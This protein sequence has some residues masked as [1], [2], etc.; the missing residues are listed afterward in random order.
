MTAPV[1]SLRGL[2]RRFHGPDRPAV[3][4][5]IDLSIQAGEFVALLGRSGSGKTTLLRTLAGLD[6]VAEGHATLPD[7]RAVVFQEPRLLPWKSVQDN[8]ALGLPGNAAQNRARALAALAEVEL[9]HRAGAWPL[10]LSGGEAQRVGLARALVR[11]PELLLLDEPFAAL[12]A[13]TR[14][15][16]QS[17]VAQ[18]VQLHRPAVLL[19]THDVEE[20]L[21]LADRVLV[22]AGGHLVEDIPVSLPRPRRRAE[23]GFDALRL[24]LLAALGVDEDGNDRAAARN[25]A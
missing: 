25:A 19:V 3:L 10:T 12:D 5:G 14:L 6:P 21:L 24:R 18:L 4:D 7:R 22:L 8:V 15:R 17:L 2:T 20:A 11:A 13:L 9:T 1:V 23:A 16:M